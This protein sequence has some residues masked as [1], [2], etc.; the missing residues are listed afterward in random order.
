MMKQK[1]SP[2][3]RIW[4]LILVCMVGLA[5][6][7]LLGKIVQS[8]DDAQVET[9]GHGEVVTGSISGRTF[10]GQV[11][12]YLL[13]DDVPI[14]EGDI[15]LQLDGI[16]RAYGLGINNNGLLWTDGIVPYKIAPDLPAQYRISDAIRH[17]QAV[18][19]IRFVE[20]TL[21]N[22]HLYPNYVYFQPSAGCSS[23]VGMIGGRQPINLALGCSTGNTVHEIGHALGLWHEHSRADRDDYVTIHYENI[24]PQYTYAFDQHI[25]DGDDIGVYDYSSIMHYPRVAFSKNG[26]PTI[27]PHH[28]ETIGQRSRLSSD[29]IAAIVH[30]YAAEI[31]GNNDGK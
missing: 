8:P 28:N 17:W 21:D 29:D 24:L 2:F 27:L 19:P 9:A 12:Q 26:Q 30:L 1:P 25:S 4:Q 6:H 13:V 18:T 5:A 3:Y 11:V 15:I 23:Y 31:E 22:Q 14:F 7:S 20:R 16:S 10:E